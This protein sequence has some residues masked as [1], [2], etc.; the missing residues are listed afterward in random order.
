MR[1]L[2]QFFVQFSSLIIFLILEVFSLVLVVRHHSFQNAGFVNS[3]NDVAGRSFDT[4]HNF[5]EYLHLKAI[6][7]SLVRENA[8]LK[9]TQFSAYRGETYT[10]D[11][12]CNQEFT[13]IYTYISAKVINKTTD[14]AN[15]YILLNRGSDHKIARDMGVI[16]SNGVVGIVKD[17]SAHFS[18]IM[19]VI[20]KDSK[21]SVKIGQSAYTGSLQWQGPDP[22]LAQVM[23]VPNHVK[24]KEGDTVF[25]SGYSSIFPENIMVGTIAKHK[26]PSGS[27]FHEITVRLSTNFEALP[28]VYVVN[29]LLKQEQQ[30]LED[31]TQIQPK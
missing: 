25:T 31:S 24:L 13:Q 22:K 21:I 19:P 23:N 1:N 20:H 9:G 14:K 18:V 4:Y 15:N 2:F 8:I 7:D 27:N 30:A 12:D 26:M 11:A 28:Y 10:L 5:T 6:N 16:A 17:V 3:A 29:Y